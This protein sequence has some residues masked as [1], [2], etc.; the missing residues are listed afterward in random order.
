MY[1]ILLLIFFISCNQG[2]SARTEAFPTK[3]NAVDHLKGAKE[4]LRQ[5]EGQLMIVGRNLTEKEKVRYETLIDSGKK[6]ENIID[7]I[8]KTQ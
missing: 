5:E 4:I 6:L 7:L 1:R 2:P 8:E 3:L